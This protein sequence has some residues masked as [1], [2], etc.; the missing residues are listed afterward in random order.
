MIFFS[1]WKITKISSGTEKRK[2]WKCF[3]P[4]CSINI[5]S[6]NETCIVNQV[7]R[8]AK[9]WGSKQHSR[10]W[11]GR[12]NTSSCLLTLLRQ[13]RTMKHEA[14]LVTTYKVE[15]TLL[16]TGWPKPSYCWNLAELRL[17]R[18][19]QVLYSAAA[20]LTPPVWS[21]NRLINSA[22]LQNKIGCPFH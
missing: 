13:S 4:A 16:R 6:L 3:H 8:N 1:W 17:S 5:R 15:D 18:L 14:T 10:R 20:T 2:K 21:L 7:M 9:L 11:A 12:C 22:F 19:S